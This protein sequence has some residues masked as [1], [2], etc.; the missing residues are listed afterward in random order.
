MDMVWRMGK[1]SSEKYLVI[2]P[3]PMTELLGFGWLVYLV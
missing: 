3:K 2:F 1:L